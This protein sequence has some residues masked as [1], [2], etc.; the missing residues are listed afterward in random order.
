AAGRG[1]ALLRRRRGLDLDGEADVLRG[2]AASGHQRGPDAAGEPARLR[3][4]LD[5][6]CDPQP[7][8]G[9]GPRLG[10]LADTGVLSVNRGS[11]TDRDFSECWI[12]ELDRAE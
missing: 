1:G 7:P 6:L 5:Q 12:L 8:A 2:H 4:G 10:V 11:A 9:A 3:R